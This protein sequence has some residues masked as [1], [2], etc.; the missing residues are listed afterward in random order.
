MV[1]KFRSLREPNLK[2]LIHDTDGDETTV[3]FEALN[4]PSGG[5]IGL[6]ETEETHI[7]EA[8]LADKRN[9][10][11]YMDKDYVERIAKKKPEPK[12]AP[13][14]KAPTTKQAPKMQKTSKKK[15]IKKK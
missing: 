14:K 13:V 8:M 15:A 1:Y 10:V 5:K 12:E 2:I 11:I 3:Q 6:F 7:A 9:G 4:G